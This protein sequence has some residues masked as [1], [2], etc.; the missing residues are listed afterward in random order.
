MKRL[1]L[2]HLGGLKFTQTRL[3]YLQDGMLEAFAAIA[4]LCGDKTI[5]Y[6][7]ELIAGNVTPGFISYGGEL[8]EFI[9][10]VAGPQ[11]K[12][13]E[14]N[15][16]YTYANNTLQPVEYIKRANCAVLGDFPFTDLRPMG[17]L[18]NYWLP[19]DLKMKCVDAVYEAENFDDDGYGINAEKGWRIFSKEVPDSAGKA[20]V[21]KAPGDPDFGVVGNVLAG[22]KKHKLT[23]G[24]QGDFKINTTNNDPNQDATGGGFSTVRTKYNDLLPP[25]GGANESSYGV[26]LIVKLRDVANEHNNIQPSF[27]ILTLIKL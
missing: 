1:D 18:K 13:T 9:G 22:E 5:L 19:G 26:D 2:T 10:G 3:K 11:V 21:N 8:I 15:S 27:V 14:D 12:I 16:A 7:V 25:A 23:P 20:F 4:K 17:E 24:E 6:G